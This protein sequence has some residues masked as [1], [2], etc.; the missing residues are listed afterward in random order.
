[1]KF[2][3]SKWDAVNIF[4]IFKALRINE[5]KRRSRRKENLTNK[6]TK[7]N[8]EESIKRPYHSH[9]IIFQTFVENMKIVKSAGVFYCHFG[10][11]H[12]GWWYFCDKRIYDFFHKK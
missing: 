6:T 2:D 5:R 8:E 3:L 7:K 11:L 10:V 12:F 9:L 1:M 4:I